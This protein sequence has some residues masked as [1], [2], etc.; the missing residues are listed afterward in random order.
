[1]LN[2][3]GD[4][5]YIDAAGNRPWSAKRCND[6]GMK[7]ITTRRAE[8]QRWLPSPELQTS[9][10][11][12]QT[13]QHVC[14]TELGGVRKGSCVNESATQWLGRTRQIR[15]TDEDSVREPE[16]T[17]L[18]SARTTTRLVHVLAPF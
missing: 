3:A 14:S 17:R 8:T 6:F 11:G 13:W 4:G 7:R 18:A 16:V 15:I 1:V 2:M 10:G 9:S 12:N 5:S